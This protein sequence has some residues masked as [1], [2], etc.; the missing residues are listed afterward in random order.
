MN[1]RPA[2]FLLSF[3]IL[4][5]TIL[6]ATYL[7]TQTAKQI[8][9]GQ[10][11]IYVKGCAQKAIQSD[12]VKWYGSITAYGT[13]QIEA[14]EKIEKD[15]EIL[16]NTLQEEG[17]QLDQV[18]FSAFTTNPI[19]EKNKEGNT[20][21]TVEGYE[22]TLSFSTSSTEIDLITKISQ[23]ITTLIKE[24]LSIYSSRPEYFY[25][26]LEELK[27]NMLGEA[28]KDARLR[29]EELISKSGG[30]RVGD[31]RSAQQGVFQITP[32]Y[33]TST[34]DYGEFDTS[35]IEKRIKAVVTLEYAI[36]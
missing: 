18:E 16:R 12:F 19:Y 9:F 8:K 24:G 29:A 34:S 7:V 5:F 17:L 33:S 27:I 6:G 10:G 31:L 11:T 26:N 25:L 28:A 36:Q 21:N 15:I 30:G 2:L 32:A 20:T 35:S 22:L 23:N 4:A 3:L 13:T 1:A 14:Y